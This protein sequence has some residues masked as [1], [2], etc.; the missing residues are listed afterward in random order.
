VY[1][2]LRLARLGVCSR[3]SSTVIAES[4]KQNFPHHWK[5]SKAHTSPRYA[6]GFQTSVQQNY[7]GNKQNSHKI[8]KMKMFAT[9]DKANPN[10]GNIRGLNLAA[11]KHTTLQVTRLLL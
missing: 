8:M 6:H 4:A 7:V 5:F 9:L 10:T 1:H 11:V 2:N 3:Q